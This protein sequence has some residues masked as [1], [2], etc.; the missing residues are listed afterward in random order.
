VEVR[1]ALRPLRHTHHYTG[2]MKVFYFIKYQQMLC[3]TGC[4]LLQHQEKGGL[5]GQQDAREQL[6][7]VGHARRDASEGQGSCPLLLMGWLELWYGWICR[8]ASWRSF[9]REAPEC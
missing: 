8:T 7:R 5:A 9:A 3:I 4:H 2:S 6:H 1:H